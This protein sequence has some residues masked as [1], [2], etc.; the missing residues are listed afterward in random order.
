M[1][2]S[3]KLITGVL[4]LLASVLICGPAAASPPVIDNPWL[5]Q[6]G[7]LNMAHQGGEFEAP[8]STM[9]AF[10]TALLNRGADSLEMDVNATLDGRLA[11][12][13]D[14]YTSKITPL[15]AQVR[16]LTLAQ[17][18]NL[19]AAYWFSPGTGQFNHSKPVDQYP[20]RGVR[21]GDVPPP[22]GYLATDFRVPSIEE[23]LDAFPGVPINIEIK[24]VPG[25]P[26]EST[27]V[28][29]LL[30]GVLN[31]PEYN[32]RRIIVASLDQDALVTFHELAPQIDLSASLGS[33]IAF[34]GGG[35]LLDPEPVAMQVPMLI[36]E[37]DPPQ[38][39]KEK[40][41]AGMG[42]AVHAWT[43]GADTENDQTYAHLI[44]SGVQGIMS[45][46]PS[47]LADYLCRTGM[48]RP[49]GEPRCESQ[50]MKYSLGFPSRS[51]RRYLKQGLPV[52]ANC[53]QACTVALEVRVKTGEA[54]RLGISGKPRPIDRGLV[55]IGTMKRIT[56]PSRVG[57]NVFY[58]NAFRQPYWRL[59]KARRVTLEITVNVY[60]GSGWKQDV[61]R[62]WLTLKSE[63]PLRPDR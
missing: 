2:E 39:L 27:R 14:Y 49:G 34:M 41:V 10:H 44:D 6:R 59:A 32:D 42:Y 20:W 3:R 28:A 46:S 22:E 18:Q 62:R 5:N 17:L 52:R 37:L 13:H 21:T 43:D 55:L 57:L 23:V 36:G 11:V 50:V 38:V 60:D 31:R 8:S 19:D 47:V 61:S 24:T 15:D 40:D 26:T 58:A 48:R 30:A 7:I 12:M 56:G 16:D 53:D 25:V 1:G 63:K 35:E 45:S 54:K 9:Y 4:A 33:M 51:L 29:T